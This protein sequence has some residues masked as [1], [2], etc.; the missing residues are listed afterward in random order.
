LDQK[1]QHP[2]ECLILSSGSN[3][4]LTGLRCG[5]LIRRNKSLIA[6]IPIS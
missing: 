4:I 6:R 1:I 5:V 3:N 2:Q